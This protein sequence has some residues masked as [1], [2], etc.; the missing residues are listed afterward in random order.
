MFL[1]IFT[2]VVE[3]VTASRRRNHTGQASRA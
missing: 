3:H 1:L 2:H